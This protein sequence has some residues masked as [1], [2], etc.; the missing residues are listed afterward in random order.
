MY[1]YYTLC[2][3]YEDNRIFKC[4]SGSTSTSYTGCKF[5]A[6]FLSSSELASLNSSYSPFSSKIGL[7]FANRRLLGFN[8]LVIIGLTLFTRNILLKVSPHGV[9]KNMDS[10]DCNDSPR[11]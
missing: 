3:I 5:R 2:I 4:Y 9:L 10:V 6:L 8:F 11:L 7:Q 1:R